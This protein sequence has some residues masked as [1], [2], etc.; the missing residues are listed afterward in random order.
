MIEVVN[1][2]IQLPGV[3]DVEPFLTDLLGRKVLV[4]PGGKLAAGPKDRFAC[5][6][7]RTEASVI[8][9]VAALDVPLAV[10]FGAALA[11]LPPAIATQA[12]TSGKFTEALWENLY[13]VLNVTSRWFQPQSGTMVAIDRVWQSAEVPADV[14]AALTSASRRFEAKVEVQGYGGG[15]L[16]LAA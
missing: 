16:L 11:A 14:R 1:L 3:T 10:A 15:M 12:A 7:Y 5:A 4:R 8:A 6:V 2:K 9:G 13:E